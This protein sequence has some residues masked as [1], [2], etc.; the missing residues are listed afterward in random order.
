M[1]LAAEA[2]RVHQGRVERYRALIGADVAAD[3]RKLTSTEAFTTGV[4]GDTDTPPGPGTLK[5][6][7]DQRRAFLLSH[8]E[9]S[10]GRRD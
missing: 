2:N 3:T 4:Y 8:P 10:A 6:F 1:D 7:A 9:V 5:A